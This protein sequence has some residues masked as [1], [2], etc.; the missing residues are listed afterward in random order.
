MLTPQIDAS[1]FSN[2]DAPRRLPLHKYD[3]LGH[4]IACSMDASRLSRHLS[5]HQA[6]DD[7]FIE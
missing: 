3:A 4:V 2:R 5:S 7:D 6:I 1:I